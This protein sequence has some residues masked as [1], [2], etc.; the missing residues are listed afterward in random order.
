MIEQTEANPSGIEYLVRIDGLKGRH[1]GCTFST[2]DGEITSTVDGTEVNRE[3][4]RS[5]FGWI[6]LISMGERYNRNLNE[7]IQKACLNR[8]SLFQFS[9]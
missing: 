7:K 1:H 8:D 9:A 2:M 4:N 3:D 6:W 5:N